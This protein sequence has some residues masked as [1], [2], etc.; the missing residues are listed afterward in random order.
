MGNKI[1]LRESSE[2]QNIQNPKD[3]PIT[4]ETVCFCLTFEFTNF[5][6]AA[7]LIGQ[8]N[9]KFLECSALTKE[10]LKEVFDE[11]IKTVLKQ[12]L[13]RPVPR[14]PKSVCTLI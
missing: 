12:K 1:D 2:F 8:K 14:K 13:E 10:G 4:S 9:C 7:S 3:K 11:A 6:Q 5:K